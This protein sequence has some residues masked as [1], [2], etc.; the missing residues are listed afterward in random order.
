MQEILSHQ[1]LSELFAAH[2]LQFQSDLWI[3]Y[4]KS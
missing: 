1:K 3:L 2:I 4:V